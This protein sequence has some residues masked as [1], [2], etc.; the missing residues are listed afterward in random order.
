MSQINNISDALI[1]LRVGCLN[2]NG[3][4]DKTKRNF[5]LKWLKNKNETIIFL[6][7]CDSTDETERLWKLDWGGDIVFNHGTSNSTGIAVLLNQNIVGD[8]K[9]QIRYISHLAA[10]N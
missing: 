10:L 7:V 4:G 8:I 9:I 6:Q 1:D 2:A 3:L 5:V